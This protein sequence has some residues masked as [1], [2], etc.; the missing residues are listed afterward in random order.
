MEKR[1]SGIF[2]EY[3]RRQGADNGVKGRVGEE[4]RLILV[5]GSRKKISVDG[6][7]KRAANY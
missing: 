6:T 1:K 5:L 3:R 7:S 2:R 4:R